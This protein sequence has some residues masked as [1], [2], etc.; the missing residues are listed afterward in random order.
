MTLHRG[1]VRGSTI[2]RQPR[3]TIM[4]HRIEA[5]SADGQWTDTRFGSMPES[6]AETTIASLLSDHPQMTYRIVSD[7]ND[8]TAP[9]LES[10]GEWLRATYKLDPVGEGPLFDPPYNSTAEQYEAACAMAGVKP[11][12]DI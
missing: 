4:S 6:E 11:V 9:T 3:E 12:W 8:S 7:T 10:Y 1:A 5:K 2:K